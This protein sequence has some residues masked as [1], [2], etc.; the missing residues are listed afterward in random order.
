MNLFRNGQ[1]ILSARVEEEEQV[2]REREGRRE[3]ERERKRTNQSSIDTSLLDHVSMFTGSVEALAFIW[4]ELNG[5]LARLDHLPNYQSQ[6]LETILFPLSLPG[7]ARYSE[8]TCNQCFHWH[9]CSIVS[10]S[11]T[12]VYC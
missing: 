4:L 8:T 5:F 11:W 7:S 1:I 9:K 10:S 3:R 12:L 6:V 2:E